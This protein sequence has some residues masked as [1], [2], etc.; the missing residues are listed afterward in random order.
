VKF[1]GI[2]RKEETIEYAET[3]WDAAKDRSKWDA[4]KD[5][6]VSLKVSL[7]PIDNQ[8][9]LEDITA[10]QYTPFQVHGVDGTDSG[11]LPMRCYVKKGTKYERVVK[12]AKDSSRAS[13]RRS[14]SSRASPARTATW[15]SKSLERTE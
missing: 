1:E 13:P 3:S 7:R 5:K 12:N 4:L 2:E 11:G 15:W 10:A 14:T 8:Y 6:R 9:Q